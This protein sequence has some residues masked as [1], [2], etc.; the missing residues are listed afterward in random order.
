M[1]CKLFV[2][3]CIAHAFRALLRL[4][5]IAVPPELTELR[6]E[7]PELLR[8]PGF[9]FYPGDNARDQCRN[10][11]PVLKDNMR[12]I[13]DTAT[14][15]VFWVALEHLAK[16]VDAAL[17]NGIDLRGTQMLEGMVMEYLPVPVG[18]IDAQGGHT[19]EV[20]GADSP[21]AVVARHHF[22][23]WIRPQGP[24]PDASDECH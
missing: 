9:T 3:Y 8:K 4:K 7:Q 17:S 12:I 21:V 2:P 22:Q 14:H 1:T 24:F 23:S 18:A 5:G 6:G 20:D 15:F 16:F 11:L 19:V 13:Q 10:L